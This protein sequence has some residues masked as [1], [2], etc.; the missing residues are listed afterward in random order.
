MKTKLRMNRKA[1]KVIRALVRLRKQSRYIFVF[2]QKAGLRARDAEGILE[3][4]ERDGYKGFGI[5]VKDIDGMKI[6]EKQV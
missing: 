6:T 5:V 1:E 3:L 2:D 4:L